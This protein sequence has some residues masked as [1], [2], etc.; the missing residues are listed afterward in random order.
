[1]E[2]R[3]TKHNTFRA[4][5]LEYNMCQTLSEAKR[6]WICRGRVKHKLVNRFKNQRK[7]L[8]SDSEFKQNETTYPER[9]RVKQNLQIE[10]RTIGKV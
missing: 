6:L 9:A 3:V 8:K 1:M 10:I 5:R 2:C 7:R 4:E